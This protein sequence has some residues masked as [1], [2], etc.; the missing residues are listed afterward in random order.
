MHKL[1]RWRLIVWF[2]FSIFLVLA[3]SVNAQ[4][5]PTTYYVAVDGTDTNP[6]T[7]AQPFKTL[8]KG[9]SVLQSGD[10]L[11]VKQGLYKEELRNT[12]PSGKSWDRPVTLRAYPG[13]QVIIQPQNQGARSG[14]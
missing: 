4:A 11:L 8:A 6:G 2:A 9:V 13:D 14:D 7:E 5:A 3:V 12:I 10:T 1:K